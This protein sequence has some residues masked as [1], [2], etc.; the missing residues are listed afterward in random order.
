MRMDAAW[1]VHAA[2]DTMTM[3]DVEPF[4]GPWL[5]VVQGQHMSKEGQQ[6]RGR[7]AAK[8]QAWEV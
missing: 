5:R 1:A 7:A 4:A 2:G 3:L 8:A 6:H